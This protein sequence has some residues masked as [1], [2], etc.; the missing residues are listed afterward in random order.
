M[1]IGIEGCNSLS[2]TVYVIMLI[3]FTSSTSSNPF[4]SQVNDEFAA[5]F[6]RP[7]NTESPAI[8]GDILLPTVPSTGVAPAPLESNANKDQSTGDLHATLDRVAK[9]LGENSEVLYTQDS[10][11]MLV[12]LQNARNSKIAN[13]DLVPL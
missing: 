1:A 11:S 8:L 13:Q 4:D 2:P 5:V 12:K 7:S 9:S 6:G 10:K 3:G